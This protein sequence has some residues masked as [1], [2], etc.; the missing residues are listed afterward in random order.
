MSSRGRE[1]E[2]ITWRFFAQLLPLQRAR[3]D[4]STQLASNE[5]MEHDSRFGGNDIRHVSLQIGHPCVRTY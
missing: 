4:Q 3:S 1:Q 2:K 5:K